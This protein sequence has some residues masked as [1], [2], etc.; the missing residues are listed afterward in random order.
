MDSLKQYGGPAPGACVIRENHHSEDTDGGEL[1]SKNPVLRG[2][3]K[4][5]E[6]TNSNSTYGWSSILTINYHYL[7]SRMRKHLYPLCLKQDL[8][9]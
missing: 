2:E 9:N 6:N 1:G 8:P 4:S 5:G 3:G 7:D